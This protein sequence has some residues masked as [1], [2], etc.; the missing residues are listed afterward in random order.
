MVKTMHNMCV[1][2]VYCIEDRKIGQ[3]VILLL[4]LFY[5]MFS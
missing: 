5:L 4:L 1:H 2:I 3:D